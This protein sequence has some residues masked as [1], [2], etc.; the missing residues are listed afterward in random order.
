VLRRCTIDTFV[1][2]PAGPL[3]ANSFSITQGIASACGDGASTNSF[4]TSTL[5]SVDVQLGPAA[6]IPCVPTCVNALSYRVA[7]AASSVHP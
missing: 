3:T 1:K 7:S 2:T 4:A 5:P 6:G